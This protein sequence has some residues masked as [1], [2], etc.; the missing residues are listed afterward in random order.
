MVALLAGA[1]FWIDGICLS[2][3][4]WAD[5][6]PLHESNFWEY[7]EYLDF[8]GYP[9]VTITREVIGDTI[10]PN[11]KTYKVLRERVWDGPY[12]GIGYKYERID[13]SG[14]VYGYEPADCEYPLVW[15]DALL[16]RLAAIVGDSLPVICREPAQWFLVRRDT[17]QMF[18]K[19]RE[20]VTYELS[21]SVLRGVIVTV[22]GIGRI[23][24]GF[25][26]GD[27]LLQGAVIQGI[28]YGDITVSVETGGR[29]K[30]EG[31]RIA[32][33]PNPF[34]PTTTIEYDIPS[35]T[36]VS[37][38]IYNLIGQEVAV[39][40]N[41]EQVAGHKAVVFNADGLPSGVYVCRLT[42]GDYVAT[43]KLIL[44]R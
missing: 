14:D 12:P 22:E 39:L 28:V 10:A 1:L 40:V 31:E 19:E 32:I 24:E 44:L 34:N 21:Y 30:P 3:T 35:R 36:Q 13:S 42:A 16:L 43:R 18:G 2:Q 9:P 7:R 17:F 37:L 41:E 4:N 20:F 29:N 26:G 8:P 23:Q 25:E 11:G 33:Y 15:V 6:Y 38:R 27:F 5:Y